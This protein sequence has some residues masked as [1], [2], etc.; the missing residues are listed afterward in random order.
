MDPRLAWYSPEQLGLAHDLWTSICEAQIGVDNMS[1]NNSNPNLDHRKSQEFISLN[2]TNNFERKCAPTNRQNN[3]HNQENGYKRKWGNRASTYGLNH[4]NYK[5]LLR[6]DGG[7]T[8]WKPKH[9]K[10]R[11]DILG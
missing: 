8:P 4:S 6:E 11:P 7:L 9:K 10:Y 5:H 3:I 1:L 2:Y